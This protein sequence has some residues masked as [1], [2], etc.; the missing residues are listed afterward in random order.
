MTRDEALKLPRGTLLKVVAFPPSAIVEL[1][2]VEQDTA[3]VVFTHDH[4][5]YP[6]GS[7]GR[8]YLRE[9]EPVNA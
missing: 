4:R 5:G 6:R 8:Y 7:L 2:A 1:V 3:A 9:M